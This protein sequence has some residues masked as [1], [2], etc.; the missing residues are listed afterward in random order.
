MTLEDKLEQMKRSLAVMTREFALIDKF[1]ESID[2]AQMD[3]ALN[4]V[5]EGLDRLGL[6][7]EAC[8]SHP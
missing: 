6:A 5:Q 8:E 2:S 4:A 7:I 1:G 3:D